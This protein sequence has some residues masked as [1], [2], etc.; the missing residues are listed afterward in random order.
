MDV[1]IFVFELYF[2]FFF[3]FCIEGDYVRWFVNDKLFLLLNCYWIYCVWEFLCI[4]VDDVMKGIDL[5][6][7]S[8]VEFISNWFLLLFL[9]CIFLVI[10]VF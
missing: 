2:I 9:W 10:E 6:E 7:E 5:S 4:C 8:G 3:Y 1:E